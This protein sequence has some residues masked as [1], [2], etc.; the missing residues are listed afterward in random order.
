MKEVK[1]L[2][3]HT[4]TVY[5]EQKKLN[6]YVIDFYVHKKI[7]HKGKAKLTLYF[8]LFDYIGG[9]ISDSTQC[10]NVLHIAS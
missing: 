4:K 8:R 6:S 5:N 3:W 9:F 1:Q 7:V 10:N 2:V